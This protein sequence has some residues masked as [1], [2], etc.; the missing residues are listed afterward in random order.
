MWTVLPE[1][2]DEEPEEPELGVGYVGYGDGAELP[3]PATG[4]I[5]SAIE[6]AAPAAAARVPFARIQPG[7]RTEPREGSRPPR[8]STVDVEPQHEVP[9][10][11]PPISLD[12]EVERL[13]VATRVLRDPRPED[14]ATD[15]PGR[16]RRVQPGRPVRRD[17]RP[18][19]Q[20]AA[21]VARLR[22][23]EADRRRA[24]GRPDRGAR[25]ERAHHDPD[26]PPGPQVVQ[27]RVA[28]PSPVRV[29]RHAGQRPRIRLDADAPEQPLVGHPPRA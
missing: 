9:A 11:H 10:P 24:A 26:R 21:P 15:A 28:R 6:A 5:A 8:F 27:P 7:L 19:G 23:A 13:A 2:E 20:A 4:A 22:R 25:V 17:P 1:P 3:S 12:H 14:E 16:H 29:G 18:R